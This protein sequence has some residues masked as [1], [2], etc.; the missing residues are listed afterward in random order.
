MGP[1]LASL[2]NRHVRDQAH[3]QNRVASQKPKLQ[4]QRLPQQF[5]DHAVAM[6]LLAAGP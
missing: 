4:Q 1:M 5:S 6:A 2:Q 3:E